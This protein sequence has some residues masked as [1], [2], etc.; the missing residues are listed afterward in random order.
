MH[1]LN[2]TSRPG[3]RVQSVSWAKGQERIKGQVRYNSGQRWGE[4]KKKK[5][6]E[7]GI[8]ANGGRE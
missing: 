6:K 4:K 8:K 5:K 2:L 3:N 7:S 1:L